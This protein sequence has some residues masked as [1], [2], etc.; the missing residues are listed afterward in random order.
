M[1]ILVVEDDLFVNTMLKQILESAGLEV[2]TAVD[3]A[4]ALISIA[5]TEPNVILSDLDL[6]DG[7]NGADLVSMVSRKYPWIN[8]IVLSTHRNPALATY[9]SSELPKGIT[10]ITKG[11]L[12]DKQN[13]I[14]LINESMLPKIKE[15]NRNILQLPVLNSQQ[16]EV[17]QL[18]AKGLSNQ[19][20]ADVRGVSLR[21]AEILVTK[22]YEVLEIDN[23]PLINKRLK[24][25]EIWRGGK[26][27]TV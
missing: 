24:A 17:L 26:V 8:I 3:V 21:A 14:T 12:A 23:D 20:I 4:G 22:V 18:I 16:S 13:L 11:D 15:E 1:K 19:A 27:L 7:P 25:A 9:P 2:A 6:G 10:Y 5:E